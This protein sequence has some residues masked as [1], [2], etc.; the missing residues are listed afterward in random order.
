M[1]VPTAARTR[2][3]PVTGWSRIVVFCCPRPRSLRVLVE[4]MRRLCTALAVIPRRAFAHAGMWNWSSL[5][6]S[7]ACRKPGRVADG[8]R[9]RHPS[10]GAGSRHKK[11]RGGPLGKAHPSRSPRD[12]RPPDHASRVSARRV[13]PTRT[14]GIEDDATARTASTRKPPGIHVDGDASIAGRSERRAAGDPVPRRVCSGPPNVPH[15]STSSA[16][17]PTTCHRAHTHSLRGAA[18]RTPTVRPV[19]LSPPASY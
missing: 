5:R 11:G 6:A 1:S 14:R 9:P 15:K 19:G 8:A 13:P 16:H 2:A 17:A 12:A 7:R 3:D 18:E 4:R 10:A